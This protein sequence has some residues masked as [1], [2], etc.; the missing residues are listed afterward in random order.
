[1]QYINPFPES[2]NL[3]SGWALGQFYPV[4]EGDSWPSWETPA[5]S[6]E[7]RPSARRRGTPHHAG[8]RDELWAQ[9]VGN[10][11][12]R[13]KAKLQHRYSETPT[14]ETAAAA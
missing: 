2:V 12:R 4:Q 1:V 8:M 13:S 11:E 10:R 6:P 3:P 5:E 7:Q 14:R 9:G